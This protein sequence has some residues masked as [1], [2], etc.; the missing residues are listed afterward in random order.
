MTATNIPVGTYGLR[1]NKLN[2]AAL[3]A[4]AA[5]GNTVD[6]MT[7]V[8]DGLTVVDVHNTNG[9]ATAHDVGYP[10]VAKLAGQAVTTTE[11]VAAG[12]T[13]GLGPF[14]VETYGARVHLTAAHAELT[15][16]GRRVP[17]Q[18]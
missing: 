5:V 9:S 11:T 17:R 7:L 4:S 3:V 10:T 14:D 16:V 8:N 1:S 15:F 18:A 2:V 6:G 13:I 12:A